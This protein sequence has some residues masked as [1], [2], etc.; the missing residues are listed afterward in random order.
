MQDFTSS[1]ILWSLCWKIAIDEKHFQYIYEQVSLLDSGPYLLVAVVL[2]RMTYRKPLLD[3][4]L[5][6]L[7][8]YIE[9]SLIASLCLIVRM[10]TPIRVDSIDYPNEQ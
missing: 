8:K 10:P 9:I 4:S 6:G 3:L 5:S 7:F 1:S 2:F